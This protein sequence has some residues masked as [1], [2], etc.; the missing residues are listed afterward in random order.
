MNR[1]KQQQLNFIKLDP[2]NK[3]LTEEEL[4]EIYKKKQ[5]DK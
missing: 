5:Q 1:R 2:N 3:N 4:A